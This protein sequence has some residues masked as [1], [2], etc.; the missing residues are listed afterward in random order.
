V[1]YYF[2]FD[3]VSGVEPFGAVISD[4]RGHLYGT[5][6]GGGKSDKGT[7]FEITP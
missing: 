4:G 2:N 3:G 5:T 1:L 7:V 6:L